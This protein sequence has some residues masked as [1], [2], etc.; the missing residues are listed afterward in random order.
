MRPRLT[1]A[2]EALGAAPAWGSYDQFRAV[3]Y[4]DH[5]DGE[6]LLV[7]KVGPCGNLAGLLVSKAQFTANIAEQPS[8]RVIAKAHRSAVQFRSQSFEQ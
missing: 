7:R 6:P 5:G 4:S 8:W 2:L 3:L 1:G